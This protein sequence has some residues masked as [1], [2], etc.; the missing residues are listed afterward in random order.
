MARNPKAANNIQVFR[1]SRP[2]E[3]VFSAN[4][5]AGCCGSGTATDHD[6]LAGRT[7]FDN[8]LAHS[9]PSG[10]N[11]K[12]VVPYGDG[13]ADARRDMIN[14]I[15]TFGVGA[16][17]S[18]LAIPTY[19]FVTGVGIHI[20]ASEP[21]LTFNLITRNGLQL[22]AYT[23]GSEGQSTI[24]DASA[25]D[26]GCAVTRT[27]ITL[28]EVSPFAG[29]GQL[30]ENVLFR[31]IFTRSSGG[32]FSLEADELILEVATVPAGGLVVGEFDITVSVSYNVIHRAEQ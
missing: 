13:F 7:R 12:F 11:D 9:N 6:K 25:G 30:G 31:D 5:N 15:N 20:A 23:G 8:A 18:V 2:R 21:G 27:P 17:I 1:G 32:T 16:Q 24:V 3:D 22:P 14:H 29:F 4:A 28:G 19:A 10:A 26:A